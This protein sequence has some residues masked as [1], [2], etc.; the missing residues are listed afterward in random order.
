MLS[1]YN[2]I[3]A[4]LTTL[5]KA[6]ESSV[7]GDNLDGNIY[8]AIYGDTRFIRATLDILVN[9]EFVKDPSDSGS[10]EL[11][12]VERAWARLAPALQAYDTLA[13]IRTQYIGSA[14]AC[15]EAIGDRYVFTGELPAKDQVCGTSPLPAELSVYPVKGPVDG[16]AVHL[17]KSKVAGGAA[18]TN[19]LLQQVLDTV[20]ASALR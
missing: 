5:V 13:A 17:P 10:V 1:R 19:P 8:S 6:G 20:A 12:H 2:G 9:D 18:K 16:K 14:S 15:A 11:A 4:S 7:R 3:R